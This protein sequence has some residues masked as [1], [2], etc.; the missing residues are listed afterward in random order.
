MLPFSSILRLSA[1]AGLLGLDSTG[2]LQVM[3]SRPLVV[4]GMFGCMLGD[5][6]TGLAVG[7]LV[8]MFCIDGVPVGSLVPPDGTMAATM[9]T[10]VAIVL[11][12]ASSSVA[13]PSAAAAMGILAAVPAGVLGARAEVIQRVLTN[14]L[15]RQADADLDAGRLPSMG[16]ILATALGL[17]WL[18]GTLVCALGLGV[19]L[20]ILGWIL[21]HLP[22]EG[23]RALHWCFWLYWLLGLAVAANHFWDRRGLKY[24]AGGALVLAIF[25]TEFASSQFEILGLAVVCALMAGCWRWMGSRRG[26]SA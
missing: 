15:S 2:A 6:A 12:H 23:I 22:P 21:A 9:A 8:E 3:V 25:G 16:R 18:R 1:V 7:S 20:P 14:R 19:G 11:A 13:G 24:A 17:A 26:E 4:G 10:A 5:T